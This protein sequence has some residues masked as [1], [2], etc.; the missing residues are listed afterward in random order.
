MLNRE[1]YEFLSNYVKKPTLKKVLM[2]AYKFEQD[3]LAGIKVREASLLRAKI[4]TETGFWE[5]EL[6]VDHGKVFYKFFD[7]QMTI[8]EMSTQPTEDYLKDKDKYTEDEIEE[9]LSTDLK[10][11]YHIDLMDT[12]SKNALKKNVADDFVLKNI[13]FDEKYNAANQVI[14]NIQIWRKYF[15]SYIKDFS[16]L[17]ESTCYKSA[18]DLCLNMKKMSLI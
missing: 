17:W 1:D 12:D 16:F 18:S 3:A 15:M 8:L 4:S 14:L 9:I 10:R 2:D 5:M 13:R 6:V 11:S 7:K